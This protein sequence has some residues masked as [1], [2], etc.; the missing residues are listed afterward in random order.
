MSGELRVASRVLRFTFY[1]LLSFLAGCKTQYDAP[2]AALAAWLETRALPSERVAAPATL[3]RCLGD[4]STL[5]VPEGGAAEALVATL[6]AEP[7]YVIAWPGVAWDGAQAQPWF[8][9]HYR[10]LAALPV[11]GSTLTPLRNHGY[12]HYDGWKTAAKDYLDDVSLASGFTSGIIFRPPYGRITLSQFRI[13]AKTYT[14]VFWDLMPHD[15]DNR[16]TSVKILTI[17]RSKVRNGSVIV[18]HDRRGSSVLTFLDDF[19]REA[20]GMGYAFLKL[21][22]SGKE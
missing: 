21:P 22:V 7:D 11:P 14:V 2:C 8:Q 4:R 9:T 6:R 13:L 18:L 16:M 1:I 3:A 5:A 20:G 10:F 19:I 17:L 12:D 15:Y